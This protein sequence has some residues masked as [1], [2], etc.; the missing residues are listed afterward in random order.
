MIVL[1]IYVGVAL[2]VALSWAVFDPPAT[3]ADHELVAISM[4]TWPFFVWL[5]ATVILFGA[6]K[7]TAMAIR[8]VMNL[9]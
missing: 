6:F 7:A 8:Y 5:G 1:Q 9:D 3:D 2:L 4:V